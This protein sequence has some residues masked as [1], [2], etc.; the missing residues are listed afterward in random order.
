[1]KSVGCLIGDNNEILRIYIDSW[2]TLVALDPDM[3]ELP[4]PK[5]SRVESRKDLNFESFTV[6]YDAFEDS[7]SATALIENRN[8]ILH[9]ETGISYSSSKKEASAKMADV[10]S[11]IT[12][13]FDWSTVDI[14]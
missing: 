9:D 11:K 14:A 12:S 13:N 2:Y 4:V 6:N 1:V 3:Q 8:F 7:Y 5:D 10:I